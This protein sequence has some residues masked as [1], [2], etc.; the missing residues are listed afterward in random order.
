MTMQSTESHK[1]LVNEAVQKK[2]KEIRSRTDLSLKPMK[3]LKSTFTDFDGSEKP[4][5]IRYY[6]VQGIMHLV[7]MKRF[8]LGDDTG[9]GKTLQ[10][11]GALCAIWERDSNRKAVIL[12][13]KSAAKQ[14]AREFAKFTTGVTVISGSGSP[15]ERQV[16]RTMFENAKGPTVYIAGYRSIVQ[17]F[18]HVQ[19]W[20]DFIFITDEATAYKNPKTQVHQVCRHMADQAERV[21]ALT[22]TLIK[23][24]LLEGHGIYSVVTPGLFGSV[25]NFTLYYCIVRMQKLPRSNRQIPIVVGYAPDR[26]REFRDEIAP[27]FLGRPKHEVATELPALVQQTIEVELSREQE[28]KYDEA[29]SGLLSLGADVKETT[30]LTQ[31]TYCQEICDHLALLDLAGDSGKLEALIELLTQGDFAD[32]KVIIFSRFRKLVDLLMPVFATNKIKAVRVTGGEDGDT[33]DAAMRAFQNPNDDTRV[34]CITMAGSD[35]INLQAAKAIIFFDTPWSAGDYIQILGRMI[36]IGSLHDRCYAVHL[37]G[38][39][40]RRKTIDHRIM[41]VQAK[42]M[43]LVEAVIGKRIKG[44]NDDTVISV[45]ND[46]SDL[47]AGLREDAKNTSD[48]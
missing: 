44:V 33:R 34:C 48:D 18:S 12:T 13:T 16:S 5:R 27:Y 4:L 3:H 15:G 25:N 2:L 22:A 24:N 7:A 26:V 9:L 23:N 45:E 20:R 21:W 30:K 37:V 19:D 36:R 43:G 31:V 29:L 6:Q 10:T 1:W 41:E 17:D 35:A 40:K 42:K 11:I 28:E 14:W 32:E 39:L 8:L 47:F 38:K 46:I